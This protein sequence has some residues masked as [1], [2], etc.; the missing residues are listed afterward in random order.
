MNEQK[1]PSVEIPTSISVDDIVKLLIR[2]FNY[3][4]GHY[5]LNFEMEMAAGQMPL[6]SD[7]QI[8]KPSLHFAFTSFS[9]Q[10][11]PENVPSAIDASEVNPK[12]NGE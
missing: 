11:V 10:R 6:P 8:G 5:I 3:H 4:E 7:K 12:F 9:L 2:Q 1:S